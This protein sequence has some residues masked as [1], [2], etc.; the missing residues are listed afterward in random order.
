MGSS[1]SGA[2]IASARSSAALYRSQPTLASTA[3]LM[4]RP[5]SCASTTARPAAA[6]T[7]RSAS[8]SRIKRA[9]RSSAFR[10]AVRPSEAISFSNMASV[11]SVSSIS[12]VMA[13][14]SNAWRRAGLSC[15][16]CCAVTR[17]PS[18]ASRSN[19]AFGSVAARLRSMPTRRIW[20]T[21]SISLTTFVGAGDCGAFLS[22]DSQVSLPF[23]RGVR[24]RSRRASASASSVAVSTSW[25]S[26]SARAL[27]PRITASS[28]NGDG[29]STPRRRSSSTRMPAS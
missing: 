5:A 25:A 2:D 24:R 17:S 4:S 13:A 12:S 8:T 9:A 27:A 29:S 14:A 15:A 10:S 7:R 28:T 16:R 20:S 11:I 6:S 21:R 1:T 26:R 18:S 19:A 3:C 22:H 23:G